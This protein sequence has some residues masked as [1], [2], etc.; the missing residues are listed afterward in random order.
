MPKGEKIREVK[1]FFDAVSL[2]P[3]MSDPMRVD[4]RL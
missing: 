4:F 2:L 3:F 1:L